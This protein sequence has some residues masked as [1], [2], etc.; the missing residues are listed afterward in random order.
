VATATPDMAFPSTACLVQA[1]LEAKNAAAFDLGAACS[2][3]LYGL[4]VGQQFIANGSLK[5]VLVIGAETMSKVTDW[6]DRNT[7]VLFGDGAGACILR[8]VAAD[9]GILS[10][11]MGSDGKGGDLLF[12]PAGGSRL[13]TSDKTV[14]EKLHYI[15]MQ[16]AEV[17]K[18]AVR[19]MGEAAV[20]ALSRSGLSTQ[21]VDYLVPHQANLRIIE[22]AR[23]RLGLSMDQV[24]I[25]LD[26]YGN[27]S[28]ASIPVALDEAVTTGRIKDGDTLVLVG[29]GAGLTWGSAVIRWG[30]E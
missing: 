8:T 6:S 24:I 16:G 1:G 29:F 17:F 15:H 26:R 28:A 13:P 3:F 7:C 22:A 12:V 18:F 11:Y 19:I 25:N 14:A 30:V 9:K 5:T 23:R 10:V 27:M 21:D 2:G 20:E 4:A